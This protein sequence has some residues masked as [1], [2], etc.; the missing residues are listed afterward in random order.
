MAGMELGD[1]SKSDALKLSRD[2]Q[3]ILE[4]LAAELSDDPETQ[5]NVIAQ[6]A[7]VSGIEKLLASDRESKLDVPALMRFLNAQAASAAAATLNGKVSATRADAAGLATTQARTRASVLDMS[8]DIY[9]RHIFDPYLRF[10]SSEDEAAYRRR[11]EQNRQAIE[12]ALADRSP[13]GDLRAARVMDRQLRD[14]GA[15]GA[16]AAPQFREMMN[17]NRLDIER[18]E[19]A[20]GRE[21]SGDHGL[22]LQAENSSQPAPATKQQL[23]SVLAAFRAAGV[24]GGM[25]AVDSGHGLSVDGSAPDEGR[26]V[27]T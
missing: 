23:A 2:Q 8:R 27:R 12:E 3:A 6:L 22:S 4:R 10:A 7:E 14:A 26:A 13:E 21:P 5:Q 15:H 11:E 1:Y 9:D 24:E 20:L 18:L 25:T 17:R 16:E 19:S